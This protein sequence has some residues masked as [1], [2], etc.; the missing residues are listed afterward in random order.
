MKTRWKNESDDWTSSGSKITEQSKLD[1]IRD[2]LE[3]SGPIILRHWHYCGGTSPSVSVFEDFEEFV[4]YLNEKSF[5]GDIIDI[6][7]FSSVCRVEN[8]LTSGK[9]PD[10]Q[11]R[12][13][14]RGAY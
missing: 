5:A 7:D 9:C 13:P 4:A 2:M 11:G 3:K 8:M 6:W 12:I 10:E 1:L 14:K